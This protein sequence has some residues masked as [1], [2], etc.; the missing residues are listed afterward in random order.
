MHPNETGVPGL[1][2]GLREPMRVRASPSPSSSNPS[3][4]DFPE[5]GT[6]DILRYKQLPK[7][8]SSPP[9]S[10]AGGAN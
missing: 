4:F 8:S 5:D 3:R 10:G 1:G 9:Q 2:G 7:H 6:L